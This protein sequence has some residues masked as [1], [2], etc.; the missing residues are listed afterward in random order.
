MEGMRRREEGYSDYCMIRWAM[1]FNSWI[2]VYI[3]HIRTPILMMSKEA[4]LECVAL[5]I[6]CYCT[7]SNVPRGIKRGSIKATHKV[8]MRCHNVRRLS[9]LL[10]INR[11]PLVPE[12]NVRPRVRTAFTD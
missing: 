9:L 3:L 6:V 8:T 1:K 12:I 11:Y 4:V 2:Q 5:V 7:K 10:S